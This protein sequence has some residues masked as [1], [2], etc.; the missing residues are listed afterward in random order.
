MHDYSW[1]NGP[2]GPALARARPGPA[3]CGPTL[4]GTAA[5]RAVLDSAAVLNREH[6]HDTIGVGPCRAGTVARQALKSHI[7]ETEKSSQNSSKIIDPSH[8]NPSKTNPS[9][10]T[11]TNPSAR[12][13]EGDARVGGRPFSCGG[14]VAV[15]APAA[16]RPGGPAPATAGPGPAGGGGRT[17]ATLQFTWGRRRLAWPPTVEAGAAAGCAPGS[18]GRW[19][20]RAGNKGRVRPGEKSEWAAAWLWEGG[21][22]GGARIYI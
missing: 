16:A 22:E 1:P 4:W 10:S 5:R 8:T 12:F 3:L 14:A 11:R 2:P 20:L 13:P 19:R 17:Q 21:G 15:P 18:C 6:G 7:E 9:R